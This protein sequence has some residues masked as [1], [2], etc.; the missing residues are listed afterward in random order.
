MGQWQVMS[1]TPSIRERNDVFGHYFA[2]TFKMKYT[3][4]MMGSFTE[5]PILEWKETITMI[6][7][8]AGTW[9]EAA[10]DQFG[11][12]PDSPT[13][14]AWTY[15]YAMAHTSVMNN[16]YDDGQASRLYDK[17]G[18]R[19]PA[20]TFKKAPTSKDGAQQVREYLK[21]HGGIMVVT[22]TDTPGI[23]KPTDATVD[24]FRL[25]TF[26]CGLKG[27]GPR[28]KALQELTVK[29][30]AEAGWQRSC[31]VGGVSSPYNTAG[32]TKVAAPADV[33]KVVPF[34]GGPHDGTFM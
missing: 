22:V 13:F 5:S 2:I 21:K 16:A 19:V 7:R 1:A 18:Q 24:K 31:A 10:F 29:G 34:S 32:L 11:R 12:L 25:L 23:N 3:A 9:W 4:S 26:D 30:L 28:I 15:R 14:G 33:T 20:T 6:E 17:N 8:T 27:M